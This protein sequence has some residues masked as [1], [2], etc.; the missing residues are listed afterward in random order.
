MGRRRRMTSKMRRR[1]RRMS[2]KMRRTRRR[3]EAGE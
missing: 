2:G 3:E 1:R